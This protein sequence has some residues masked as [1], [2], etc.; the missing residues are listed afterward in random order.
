MV[1][2]KCLAQCLVLN[3]IRYYNYPVRA[4]R[5]SV[6][7]RDLPGLPCGLRGFR[8]CRAQLCSLPLG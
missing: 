1:H 4:I 6:I 5:E 3:N 8:S 7:G 2:V